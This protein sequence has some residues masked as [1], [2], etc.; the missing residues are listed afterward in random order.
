MRCEA[1][2]DVIDNAILLLGELTDEGGS[3]LALVA[4]SAD[5]GG[6]EPRPHGTGKAEWFEMWTGDRPT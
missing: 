2:D 3:G 4:A 1:P 5:N 6:A